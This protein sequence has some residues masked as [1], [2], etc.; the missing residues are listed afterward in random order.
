M[1]HGRTDC[2]EHSDIIGIKTRY[3]ENGRALPP[4]PLVRFRAEA[5]SHLETLLV[6]IK[7]KNKVVTNNVNC[8]KRKGGEN[9]KLQQTPRGQLHL[10]TIYGS[11]RQYVMKEEKVNAS[12]DSSKI[13]TVCKQAY[14]NALLE[15]LA[16]FG[17][18]PKKAFTGK[19]SLEKNPV[20][21]DREQTA[22][23]PERGTNG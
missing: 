23:V 7:A 8:T 18:D 13:A 10:E 9:K 22:R 19:N 15:R 11:H 20:Y 16:A 1:R 17:N 12:F 4:M 14:R 6:S 2:K 5:K 21:L 3:F